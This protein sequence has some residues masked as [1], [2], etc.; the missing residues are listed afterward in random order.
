APF[1]K[2]VHLK[3]AGVQEPINLKI[4]G[5]VLDATAFD[6]YSKTDDYK[7][8]EKERLAEQSKEAKKTTKKT[9]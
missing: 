5:E 8:A 6:A 9:K 4:T 3:L 7:K 1:T 2:D